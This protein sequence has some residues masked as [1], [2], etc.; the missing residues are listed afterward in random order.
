MSEVKSFQSKTGTKLDYLFIDNQADTSLVLLHGYGANM[1]DLA[2][3]AGLSPSFKKFNWYFP[4]GILQVPIGPFMMGKAWFPIDME[5][6]NQAMISGGFDQLFAD[7][8][9]EGLDTASDCLIDFI[10]N[11]VG[12][13][14]VFGGF[15]QGSMLAN[16]LTFEKGLNPQALLLLSSTLV[17]R[18]KWQERLST[19]AWG[20][21]I[22]QSHGVD[23]PV[24][25]ISMARELKE[26][27]ENYHRKVDYIEFDGGHEI[28]PQVLQALISFLNKLTFKKE[29]Q[30]G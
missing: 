18:N 30:N 10:E 1:R 11:E 12:E 6:L 20:N 2:G 17:A 26:I 27:F 25:P 5:L 13:P 3:I 22:F 8:V 4:D 24:L 16:Y 15:S 21:P 9:P 23:D 14:F 28:P 7:H 19:S 29:E